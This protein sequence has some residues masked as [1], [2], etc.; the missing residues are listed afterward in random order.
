MNTFPL[1]S[2]CAQVITGSTTISAAH[3]DDQLAQRQITRFLTATGPL[4]ISHT[5]PVPD[6]IEWTCS[7]CGELEADHA[8]WA[9]TP[10]SPTK[11]D[12]KLA[13]IFPDVLLW[14]HAHRPEWAISISDQG[15]SGRWPQIALPDG[16]AIR[17][18][19]DMDCT[20]TWEANRFLHNDDD[21]PLATDM[22]PYVARQGQELLISQGTPGDLSPETAA[23]VIQ[24]LIDKGPYLPN[25]PRH[26]N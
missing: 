5:G 3:P 2:T 21:T 15:L 24:T 23:K 19:E 12:G 16:T 1:C 13:D 6:T 14:I 7:A 11:D 18:G 8:N 20:G 4:T 17:F 22:T 25:W 26:Y 9:T 10:T